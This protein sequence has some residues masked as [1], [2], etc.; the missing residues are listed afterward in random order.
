MK[1]CTKLYTKTVDKV[2]RIGVKLSGVLSIYDNIHTKVFLQKI[3]G[4]SLVF[5]VFL[6]LLIGCLAKE[7]A[8]LFREL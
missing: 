3:F 2:F 6:S 4:L 1:R 7:G 8:V 5:F